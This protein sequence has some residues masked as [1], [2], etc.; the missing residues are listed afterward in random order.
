M[1]W[2]VTSGEYAPEAVARILGT[3]PE[4]FG[5]EASNAEYVAKAR[6]LPAYLAWPDR[7]D[8]E[9]AGVLLAARHF[10]NAAEIYLLAVERGAHR[11][12]AGRAMVKA[13]EADLIAESVEFLQV[14][15]LGPS[16]AD[17]NYERTRQFYLAMGFQPLEEIHGLWG[18]GNP[19]LIMIKRLT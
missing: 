4:W 10:P 19:C 16:R 18:Q 1:P 6:E 3:V 8:A 15:T 9:P 11:G 14:K 7:A 17:P 5:I 13:F 2:E 12:G